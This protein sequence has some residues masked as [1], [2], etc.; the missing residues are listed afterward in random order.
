MVHSNSMALAFLR[1]WEKLLIPTSI[2]EDSAKHS[3][4]TL[5][6][7]LGLSRSVQRSA[8]SNSPPDGNC[9]I[10]EQQILLST[11]RLGCPGVTDGHASA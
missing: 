6:V 2:T 9:L 11:S 1:I 7:G 10:K 4:Q 3:E 8:S 5:T